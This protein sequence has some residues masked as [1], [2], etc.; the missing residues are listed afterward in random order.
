[1]ITSSDR[2]LLFIEPKLAPYT[3]PIIDEVTR[4]ITAAWRV[5]QS[6]DARY[7]GVHSCT[8][9]GCRATSDNA[10]HFVGGMM[11]NS[12]CIHYVAYHRDEVP[13]WDIEAILRLQAGEAEP[14]IGEMT[15]ASGAT[16]LGNV[17]AV[18]RWRASQHR[19]QLLR[20]AYSIRDPKERERMHIAAED[21]AVA[22]GEPR[23]AYTER[24]QFLATDRRGE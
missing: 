20:D 8:G 15:G 22:A 3:S 1:M 12:L 13:V 11:T 5:R 17:A 9:R 21:E 7:R 6:S 2:H 18:G 24:A 23:P 14:T 4:K 10:D 19:D 16:T